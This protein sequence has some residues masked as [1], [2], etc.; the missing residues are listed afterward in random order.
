MQI[1]KDLSHKVPHYEDHHYSSQYCGFQ[2][3][4]S[5]TDS[6][7]SESHITI[8][9]AD[10]WLLL[11]RSLCVCCDQRGLKASESISV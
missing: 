7:S 10:C 4:T 11:L 1:K 6:S 8:T 3:R 2:G 5:A 9:L